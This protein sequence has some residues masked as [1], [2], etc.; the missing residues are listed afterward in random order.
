M[1]EQIGD[2]KLREMIDSQTFFE[3]EDIT[4]FEAALNDNNRMKS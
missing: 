3:G 4:T 2:V 1:K